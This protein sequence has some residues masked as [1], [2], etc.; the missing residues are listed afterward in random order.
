MPS[1]R[2]VPALPSAV[3][4]GDSLDTGVRPGQPSGFAA[5]DALLPGG[6]WPLGGLTE[7]LQPQAG[8]LEW[9]LLGPALRGA[10]KAAAPLLLIH[11]PGAPHLPGLH[12]E[13]LGP[14]VWIDAATPQQQLWAT[15]QAVQSSGASAVLAWLPQARP[16]QMRRLQVHALGAQMPVF[17]FRSVAAREQSS[18][19]PL[20]LQLRAASSPGSIWQLEV[21][22]FKRRGPAHAGWLSLSAV[23]ATLDP[24]LTPRLR[25]IAPRPLRVPRTTP[26]VVDRVTAGF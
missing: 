13:G 26:H 4:R 21:Q 2:P 14:L 11:P 18:A 25:E 15:E 22:L 12:G 6:G 17:V 20:R 7:I 16:E 5:L 10:G 19:A 24:L 1:P 3:W 9:R 8:A 23:P